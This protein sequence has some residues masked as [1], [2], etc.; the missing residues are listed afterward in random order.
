MKKL[1][2]IIA[3]AIAVGGVSSFGQDWMSFALPNATI[4]FNQGPQTPSMPAAN[5]GTVNAVLLYSTIGA[6]DQLP[7]EG[8]EFGLRGTGVALDQVAT[9][10]LDINVDPFVEIEEM[11]SSGW[12]IAVDAATGT[13]AVANDTAAGKGGLLYNGGVPFEVQGVNLASGS[14]IE[15]VV[16]GYNAGASSWTAVTGIGWSN[17]FQNTVGTSAGDPFATATQS[18]A[19]QFAVVISPE[20]S[21]LALAG[22]GGLAILFLRRRK[23]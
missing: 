16:L 6:A 4:W 1:I 5:A 13:N 7:S 18:L 3:T 19:N 17:P 15:E 22:L 10:A 9:N 14:S 21:T 2:V 12:S 20:P 8:T 23:A 11:L